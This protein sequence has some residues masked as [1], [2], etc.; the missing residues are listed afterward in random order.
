MVLAALLLHRRL[1]TAAVDDSRR[2]DPL[3]RD[4][5]T[6]P[7]RTGVRMHSSLHRP[8]TRSEL[9]ANARRVARISR[10]RDMF[11]WQSRV[12][13][14]GL[15]LGIVAGLLAA[16]SARRKG[17]LAFGATVAGVAALTVL[18]ASMEWE[19]GRRAYYD[20]L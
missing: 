20:E 5:V 6:S 7:T 12:L 16:R 18:E 17:L 10:G 19:L 9:L 11:V 15:P 13:P 1:A 4:D 8:R 2:P 3:S 14:I